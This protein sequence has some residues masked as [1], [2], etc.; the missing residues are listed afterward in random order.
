MCP[1]SNRSTI[2]FQFSFHWTLSLCR[3][4]Y[5]GPSPIIGLPY[6][7]YYYVPAAWHRQQT[8]LTVFPKLVRRPTLPNSPTKVLKA[9]WNHHGSDN[10]TIP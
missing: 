7:S 5:E 10:A 9:S 6:A 1:A 8:M 3:S 4:Q 2:S